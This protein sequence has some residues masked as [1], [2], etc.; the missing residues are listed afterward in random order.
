[1]FAPMPE[2]PTFQ[3]LIEL[4]SSIPSVTGSVSSGLA[5]QGHWWVKFSIDIDHPLAWNVIQELGHVLNFLSL[6]EK[7]PTVF[8]P[9]SPAPY[10]NGGPREFLS[11][12][13]E[14]RA[15][16]FSPADCAEWLEGRLPRPVEDPT[17][18]NTREPDED[19]PELLT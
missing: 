16:D 18:W 8:M 7:L 12:V 17:Q 6:E 15:N 2:P 3:P 13:I 10:Q 14:C 11:W 5:E 4:V 1:M 9:V 19:E